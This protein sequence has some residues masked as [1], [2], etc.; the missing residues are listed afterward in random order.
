MVDKVLNYL[1][2]AAIL[3]PRSWSTLTALAGVHLALGAS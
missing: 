1:V 2:G 3:D